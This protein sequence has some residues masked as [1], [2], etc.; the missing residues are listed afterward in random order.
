MFMIQF[1]I[2]DKISRSDLPNT[3]IYNVFN[4]THSNSIIDIPVDNNI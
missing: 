4:D 3:D 2:K 1:C